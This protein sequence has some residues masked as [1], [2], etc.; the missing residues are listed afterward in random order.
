MDEEEIGDRRL[1]SVSLKTVNNSGGKPQ[2]GGTLLAHSKIENE[3]KLVD[4][5]DS[6]ETK[7]EQ[8]T[9]VTP[10]LALLALNPEYHLLSAKITNHSLGS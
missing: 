3:N 5:I 10:K 4:L 6:K 8:N 1:F 9:S 7:K 2:E